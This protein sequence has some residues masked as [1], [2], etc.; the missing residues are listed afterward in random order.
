MIDKWLSRHLS[1]LSRSGRHRFSTSSK[2]FLPGIFSFSAGVAESL[3]LTA[4][5][6]QFLL[7]FWRSCRKRNFIKIGLLCNRLFVTNT[8]LRNDHSNWQK[9]SD[10]SALSWGSSY[11]H[12]VVYQTK[13]LHYYISIMVFSSVEEWGVKGSERGNKFQEPILRN[14]P[15]EKSKKPSWWQNIVQHLDYQICKTFLTP[16][17]ELLVSH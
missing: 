12:V 13:G 16:S 4:I 9:K 17:A 5:L 15:A 8:F 10:H 3:P 7:S 2:R 14:Y 11:N 6:F 1:F